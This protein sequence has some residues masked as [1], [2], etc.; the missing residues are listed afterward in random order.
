MNS[1]LNITCK[2]ASYLLS[3][4]QETRLSV[5]DKLKLKMHLMVCSTC[6]LFSKQLQQMADLF[7]KKPTLFTTMNS[8]RKQKI[9]Q[10]LQKEM[11]NK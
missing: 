1:S 9:K 7:S 6:T 3:K 11:E 8:E 2:H 10:A 4:K 5:T